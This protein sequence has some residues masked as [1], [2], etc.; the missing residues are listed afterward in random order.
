MGEGVEEEKE[1]RKRIVSEKWKEEGE[2]GRGRKRE[3]E[4]RKKGV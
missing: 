4:E 1:M 2:E 3:G